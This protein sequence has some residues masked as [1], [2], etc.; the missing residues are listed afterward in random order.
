MHVT[1]ITKNLK[2]ECEL[3]DNFWKQAIGLS[4]SKPKNMLFKFPFDRRWEFWMFGMGFD[5]WMA[6]IDDDGGVFDIVKAERM[7]FNPKTWKVYLPKRPCKL[8]L[9]TKDK[10]V[11]IG[12]LATF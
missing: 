1:N 8:I 5:I 6:F 11:E 2:F 4:F 10:L 3:A 9:E 7:T 12:D